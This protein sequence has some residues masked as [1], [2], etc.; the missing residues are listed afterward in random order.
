MIR[1]SLA[2]IVAVVA[3]LAASPVFAVV[4]SQEGFET[5]RDSFVAA[6]DTEDAS[7]IE[8]YNDDE[9]AAA[10][11]YPFDVAGYGTK[12]LKVDTGDTVLSHTFGSRTSSTY[13]DA[14]VKFTTTEEG[15]AE[16]EDGTKFAIYLDAA[17]SN[18][19]VV[20]GAAVGDRTAVTN[21]LV[22]APIAP[23][24][25]GR[26]TVNL[27]SGSVFAFEVRLNGTLLA[28][29][30]SVSRFYSLTDDSTISQVLF[31]GNGAL[32]NVAVRTTDPYIAAGD[33]AATIGSESYA[34]LEQALEEANGATVA[35]DAD[36]AAV[37]VATPG[38]YVVNANGHAFGG[39]AGLGGA[40]IASSTSDSVTTYTVSCDGVVPVAVWDGN[41]SS[42]DFSTLMR[43]AYALNLNTANTVAGDGSYVQIGN[44]NQ[45]AAVTI[46]SGTS[47][48][49]GTAGKVTVIVKCSVL[50]LSDNT[51]RGLIG[52]LSDEGGYY[53]GDNNMK[54]GVTTGYNTSSG[55][56]AY[57]CYIANGVFFSSGAN[58][59]AYSTGEQTICMAYDSAS[60]TTIYR[61]GAQISAVSGL[62]YG[63]WL[64]PVGIVLGGMD[65]DGSTRVYAQTG[66]K[67]EAVAVFT[68]CLTAAEV[69]AY[70]FP[71]EQ[72]DVT[73]DIAV[74]E[75]NS[76]TSGSD[77]ILNVAD[78]V[79]VTGD[80]TFTAATN[81]NFVCD[82]SFT[83]TPP[84]GNTATFDF[85]GVTG[86]P[87]IEYT[88]MP[89]VS[90]SVFT[91]TTVPTWVTDATKWTGVIHISGGSFTDFTSNAFG[92]ESSLVRLGNVSGWLRAPGNYAFTNT[93]PVELVGTLT[94]N[95]GSSANDDNP[96]RCTV[97][98]KLS[99]NG[100][101]SAN[102]TADKVVV[103]IQDASEF[104]GN[105][106]LT[107]KLIVFGDSMPSYTDNSKF[108]NMTASIWVMEGASVTV[109]PPSGNWWATGGIKVYGELRAANLD[110]FGGGT[111]ITTYDTGVLEITRSDSS[112]VNDGA[113]DYSKVTG[114][115]TIRFA[116]SGFTVISQSIPT[117][118]TFEAEKAEASV[119]PAAGATIGSLTGSKGFRSDWGNTG[120]GGRYLTIKQSKD[121]TWSGSINQAGGHRLTGVIVDP[122]ASATGTLTLAGT[123][124]A[125]S[126]LAVNG[127][128]NLT[129]TWVGPVTVAGT[130][131]GTGTI[132]G[133]LTL[134]DGA[135]LVVDD[136]GDQLA[137]TGNF[138]TTAGTVKIY[139]PEGTRKGT[140][141]IDVTGT[142][143]I[144][145]GTRF[146]VYVGNE[147]K[148]YL[149]AKA[150]KE[151]G[152][153]KVT[154]PPVQIRFLSARP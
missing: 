139:L 108:E 60:G 100:T 138:T 26:L 13:F 21:R 98:K 68:N 107:G 51:Y 36:H 17:T 104:T 65:K 50:N 132:T 85:G 89:T 8:S 93:V 64:T 59:A 135:E 31:S 109:N 137:V 134:S 130:L 128:V 39:I 141:F 38:T 73:A 78:G 46:T 48:A 84:A 124:T 118:L 75:I 106:G 95:N 143:T 19:C 153:V 9:P 52:L 35:L 147:L 110:K 58:E 103:V 11:A 27:I 70:K 97:F 7:G 47:G 148:R 45:K 5:S 16:F 146:E 142:I 145:S 133:D 105:I 2:A 115:G 129:G 114:T 149:S 63:T 102:N 61:N 22:S 66:M 154:C 44:D 54:V 123:Q 53:S 113:T 62:K 79:T 69:A 4:L 122:G 71:S 67:I 10:A 82:G 127:S 6:D 80:T 56:G 72:V 81:V 88:T 40:T 77:I 117:S 25:W 32:D 152:G 120:A 57:S 55:V 90:G 20:S 96:N 91:S 99:G 28:T 30:G 18:L 151:G 34:T 112:S 111:Y 125:E 92:N 3:C 131:G 12:Y 150:L 74:S 76:L 140:K 121:T 49:F 43:G 37:G 119:V 23:G 33:K 83:I 87:V 86:K 136:M 14:M 116:G 126:T 1:R 29:A 24:S 101:I 144:D 15:D 42:Y 94:I 41:S